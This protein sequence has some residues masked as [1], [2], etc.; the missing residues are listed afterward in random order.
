MSAS[1]AS[2]SPS[3]VPRQLAL[4]FPPAPRQSS[5]VG[6]AQPPPVTA[7]LR[8]RTIWR[9]LSPDQQERVRHACLDL[10]VALLREER[11]NADVQ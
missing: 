8:P 2:R 9:T 5:P 1:P 4:P 11:S 7:S 10:A 3:P 6:S